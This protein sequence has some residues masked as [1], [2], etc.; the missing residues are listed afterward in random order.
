MLFEPAFFAQA[1]RQ[2][3][4]NPLEYSHK[5]KK[6]KTS[7]PSLL[8]KEREDPEQLYDS[9]GLPIPSLVVDDMLKQLGRNKKPSKKD[10]TQEK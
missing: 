3:G 2:I 7:T 1:E 9:K 5:L 8:T 4:K 10:P 6:Q